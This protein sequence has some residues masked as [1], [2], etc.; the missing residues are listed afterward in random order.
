VLESTVSLQQARQTTRHKVALIASLARAIPPS[1]FLIATHTPTTPVTWLARR[2]PA[3]RQA[4]PLWLYMDYPEM[5]AGRSVE[6]WLL[7][8]SLRWHR[9]ALAISRAG[10]TEAGQQAPDKVVYT[11]LGISNRERFFP[12]PGK[13][14]CAGGRCRLLYVGDERPRK[15]MADFLQAAALLEAQNCP[16]DVWIAT[17]EP[18]QMPLPP[19]YRH[20]VRPDDH[21][22]AALYR[23]CDI[24][25]SATWR[26]GLGLPPLEAM[27]SGAA[28]V[29][30][31]SVG[32]RD[33]ARHGENCLLVPPRNPPALA[34]ATARLANDPKLAARLIANGLESAQAFDYE[35]AT[36][37]FDAVLQ[38]LSGKGPNS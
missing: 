28:V 7:K 34:Q 5:F 26:E 14:F 38:H 25:V 10:V 4:V 27:A 17:K 19:R 31:D 29:M 3:N 12:L 21:Q 35:L 6:R 9:L 1:D 8:N 18:L 15:G 33:Y 32:S 13:P 20:L 23:E 36:D 22:L 37:R 30:T 2:L 11:G 16:T 24:F